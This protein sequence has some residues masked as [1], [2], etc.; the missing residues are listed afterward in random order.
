MQSDVLKEWFHRYDNNGNELIQL[1]HFEETDLHNHL[2]LFTS[3]KHFL[4]HVS[5][6]LDMNNSGDITKEEW[7]E[8]FAVYTT[9]TSGMYTVTLNSTLPKHKS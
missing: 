4:D 5:E 6:E 3:C 9:N 8:F 7:L 2:S 1:N